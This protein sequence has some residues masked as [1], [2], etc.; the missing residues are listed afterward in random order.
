MKIDKY[1]DNTKK[2]IG[3]YFESCC[4]QRLEGGAGSRFNFNSVEELESAL[5]NAEWAETTNDN[6]MPGCRAYKTTDIGGQIGIVPIND[7]DDNV[8]LT[9]SDPKGTGNVELT[10]SG[11]LGTVVNETWLIIGPENGVD[12]VYTFHPGAPIQ[13]STVSIDKLPAG[14]VVTKAEALALGFTYAKV[15]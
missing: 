3:G 5:R 8:V 13:P 4:S 9:A 15:A 7:L 14:S 12:V 6:V 10:C 1:I 11:Q 2:T